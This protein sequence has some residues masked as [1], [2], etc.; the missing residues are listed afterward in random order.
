MHACLDFLS[1]D[2]VDR[3]FD[4]FDLGLTVQ[5]AFEIFENF[6]GVLKGLIVKVKQDE[7]SVITRLILNK[8][9]LYFP[10]RSASEIENPG[11][12]SAAGYPASLLD[13]HFS[14]ISD[15]V[16]VRLRRALAEKP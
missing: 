13:D 15:T 16:S 3:F 7:T 5:F 1:E 11:R 2:L 12:M 9:I 8:K 6:F 14:E 10:G 4:Y